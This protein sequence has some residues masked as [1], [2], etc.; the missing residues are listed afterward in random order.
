MASLGLVC[1]EIRDRVL[2]PESAIWR[3]RFGQKYD[4]PGGRSNW[5]F[6]IEYQ[7]RALVIR[8]P[9]DFK[10]EASEHQTLW[11]EVLQQM[12]LEVLTLPLKP[13]TSKTYER[14]RDTLTKSEL[15]E[16]P[17]R[18]KPSELFCAVQLVG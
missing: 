3:T 18:E 17:L 5:E 14:I 1:K 9:I 6:Q 15:L 7:I 11:L 10:Q 12:L 8:Q 13:D 16:H 2:G 4:L